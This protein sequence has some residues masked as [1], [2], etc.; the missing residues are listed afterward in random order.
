MI[1][2]FA[3]TILVLF[4]VLITINVAYAFSLGQPFGGKIIKTKATQIQTLEATHTCVV[5]GDTIDIKSIKGP[6]SYF[7][8]YSTL[9]KTNSRISSNQQILGMYTGKTPIICT[10]KITPFTPQTVI[11]DTITLFGTSKK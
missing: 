6:I 2:I 1:K 4:F 3:R 7:I 9:P 5:P 8:S 10:L 11:L